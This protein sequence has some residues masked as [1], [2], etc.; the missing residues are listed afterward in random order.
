VDLDGRHLC[1]ACLESGK[2]KGRFSQLENQRVLYDRVALALA[3]LPLLC[4]WPSLVGA[5][6]A[7]FVAIRYRNHPTTIRGGSKTRFWVAGILATLQIIGWIVF[8][9]HLATQ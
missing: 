2:K 5:P 9:V 3:G 8:F 4:L 7:L 6:L 1:P